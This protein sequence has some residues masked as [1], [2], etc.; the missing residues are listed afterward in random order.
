MAY[1]QH[2]HNH[3]HRT[4]ISIILEMK[5]SPNKEQAGGEIG[6]NF[7]LYSTMFSKTQDI[8]SARKSDYS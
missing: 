6:E 8:I 2:A 4:M 1:L 3:Q 7:Q 5:I